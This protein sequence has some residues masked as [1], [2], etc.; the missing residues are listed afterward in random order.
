MKFWKNFLTFA[1]CIAFAF[2]FAFADIRAAS[3][4]NAPKIEWE[5]SYG[6]SGED[7][8]NSIRQTTDGGY[9]FAAA[10]ASPNDG[11]VRGNQGLSDYWVVKLD[12]KGLKMWAKSYGGTS[13]DYALDIVQ[14]TAGDYVVTGKTRSDIVFPPN[15]SDY[16]RPNKGGEDAWMVRIDEY[17]ELV[18]TL[19]SP[20]GGSFD[21]SLSSVVQSP[22]LF[23]WDYDDNDYLHFALAG[24]SASSHDQV[25]D[26]S[27]ERDFWIIRLYDHHDHYHGHIWKT[28]GGSG[29]DEA[30]SIQNANGGGYIVGGTTFSNDGDVAGENHGGADCWILKLD[31]DLNIINKR[32]IGGSE[33]DYFSAIRA[34]SDN[35]YIVAGYKELDHGDH[36]HINY[37]VVKLD[38]DLEIEWEKD[39]VFGESLDEARDIRQTSDGGYIIAGVSELHD[40]DDHD[41]DDGHEDGESDVLI[42]KLDPTGEVE[43]TMLL[44]G[45]LHDEANSI[46]QTSDGGYIIGGTSRSS[47]GDVSKNNG[48]GDCW[49]VKLAQEEKTPV[50]VSD[51]SSGGCDSGS[52]SFLFL[53]AIGAA[54]LIRRALFGNS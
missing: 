9:V 39:L 7:E 5:Y 15:A 4:A 17:G 20:R 27:G 30:K 10:S 16:P 41:H 24:Y 29:D 44:G 19:T 34:T 51:G 43:W 38:A 1:V 23:H 18:W 31:D 50:N 36:S 52:G 32:T 14:T 45:S 11:D 54:A 33:N 48:S 46:Q 2:S 35:G 12:D 8:I 6:G 21:E 13:S 42:V 47:D 26:N 37:W 49:V 28:F 22:G 3:A 40:D 25:G 53:S